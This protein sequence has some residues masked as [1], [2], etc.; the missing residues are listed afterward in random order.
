MTMQC[1]EWNGNSILSTGMLHPILRIVHA[2]PGACMGSVNRTITLRRE[3][4]TRYCVIA[5]RLN[6]RQTNSVIIQDTHNVR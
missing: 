3:D 2:G 1:M 4:Y 5:D 6:A